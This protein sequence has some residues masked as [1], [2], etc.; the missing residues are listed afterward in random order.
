MSFRPRQA[1]TCIPKASSVSTA[2]VDDKDLDTL[3]AADLL[4]PVEGSYGSWKVV[5]VYIISYIYIDIL[6]IYIYI[7]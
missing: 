2:S 7:I 4:G 1:C 6:H 3:T 5:Y